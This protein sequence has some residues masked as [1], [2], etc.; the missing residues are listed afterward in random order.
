[1]KSI[2]NFGR[3]FAMVLI[4]LVCANVAFAQTQIK[5][6]LEIPDQRIN[7]Y[8]TKE[9]PVYL[10]NENPV[11][12][13][14]FKFSLPEELEFAEGEE[15][16]PILN[17]DR[18]I[19]NNHVVAMNVKN[20]M[21]LLQSLNLKE[22]KDGDAPIMWI[23]VKVKEGMLASGKTVEIVVS[24]IEF[25]NG[26]GTAS[27]KQDN[28]NVPVML[29]PFSYTAY[30]T[31]DPLA[32]YPGGSGRV[33]FCLKNVYTGTEEA[34]PVLGLTFCIDLPEGLEVDP[35][36]IEIN[37]DRVFNRSIVSYE[38]GMFML[39]DVTQNNPLKSGYSDGAL[40][41][42][43]LKA[44]ADYV[45]KDA[46][47]GLSELEV[48]AVVG[49]F[50]VVG[51]C[52]DCALVNTD[53]LVANKAAY[54]K[55]IE[56]LDA[57]QAKYEEALAAAKKANPEF[58]FSEWE[59]M[60]PA[61]IKEAREGASQAFAA[62]NEDGVEFN[63]PFDGEEIDN[64]IKEMENAPARAELEAAN[65]AAYDKV[66][67]TLDKVEQDFNAA[68]AELE[69]EYP[70][71]DLTEWKEIISGQITEQKEGAAIA[72]EVANEDG[73]EYNYPFDGGEYLLGMIE[74]MKN[75]AKAAADQ[76]ALEAAN[77]EAC[78]KV[79]EAIEALQAKY[80]AAVAEISE[81]NPDFDFSD[82]E[83]IIMGAINQAR[84]GAAQAL[85][86]ANEDGEEYN[87]P[88]DGSDIEAMIAQ[89]KDDATT[90]AVTAIEAEVAAGNAYIFTLDG[91]QHQRPV[92]GEVNVIVR[93]S[94]TSKIFIS[95]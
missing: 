69:E 83:E 20:G 70:D 68:V 51:V 46:K 33:D 52:E 73:E 47:I 40:F 31:P 24:K 94:S 57:L 27:G 6:A 95:K 76:A 39:A 32:I 21:I 25:S 81:S 66:I 2:K 84:E 58:D 54:D 72:L 14:Q 29:E 89:M 16:E 77:L 41:S 88:F 13:L 75:A 50:A 53:Y 8:E 37:T 1:M 63:F 90:S 19:K 92:I 85:A 48:S 62:A 15:T 64:M 17:Y 61:V 86:S 67:E 10:N 4:A 28:F 34:A 55:V 11:G 3:K 26:N 22:I 42:F 43:D 30:L 79:L 74:E 5:A 60:I 82:W 93:Q 59:E 38:N 45:A 49:A 18:L 12:A 80:E 78:N 56:T 7:S 71:F 9:I 87:Y 91:K 44:S 23:P 36:S 35:E 65:K